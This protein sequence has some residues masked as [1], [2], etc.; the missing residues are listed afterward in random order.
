M[1]AF[2]SSSYETTLEF[3]IVSALFAL[4]VYV[5]VWAGLLSLTPIAL[6]A[7]GGFTYAAVQTD[8]GIGLPA[9]LAL[10][11][12]L[13]ALVS[14]LLSTFLLRL[15]THYV[16]MATIAV[17]LIGRVVVLNLD[18]T[19]GAAGTGLVRRSTTGSLLL[20]LALVCWVLARLRRARLGL[21]VET[22]R[23]DPVVA[24]ALG[25]D[26]RRVQRAMFCLSG[27][28]GGIAGVLEA[29]L[30]QYIGPNTYYVDLGFV[31]LAAV[32]LG[33]AYHWLG[34]VVG[35]LVFAFLPELLGEVMDSGE[36]IANGV[37][38][39]LI[40]IYL[41][42]GL[43]DPARVLAWRSRLAT[44]LPR[45]AAGERAITEAVVER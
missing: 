24:A 29:D 42:R 9:A 19:G 10:G 22:V 45:R 5:A 4:A 32:V 27:A 18:V 36:N 35:A 7:V 21:A 20:V 17:V 16:A 8:H 41:P 6:G 39:I 43:V 11:A 23:E 28:I 40:M 25:I 31:T 12:A 15:A 38:L 37:L 1:P 33:G 2:L 13:G 26:V 14:L 30:L 44:W 34:P 3:A